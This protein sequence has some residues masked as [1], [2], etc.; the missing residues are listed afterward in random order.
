MADDALPAA[1]WYADG[2]TVGVRRWFD[3]VGWTEYTS[4]EPEAM[5]SRFIGAAVPSRLGLSLSPED[6]A[7]REAAFLKHRI[8][9]ACRVRRGAIGAFCAAL[10]LLVLTGAV[11]LGLGGPGDIWVLGGIGAVFLVGRA[12][13]NYHRAVF[14]GAPPLSVVGWLLA[15][16]GLVA[17]LALFIAVPVEAAGQ[18]STGLDGLGGLGGLS[19]LDGLGGLGGLGGVGG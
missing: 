18:A 2:T 5:E 9:E 14:R 6:D 13:R 12:L 4:P 15:G 16:V 3:G 11:S 1:G 7:D 8:G 19:G 10:G 17:A